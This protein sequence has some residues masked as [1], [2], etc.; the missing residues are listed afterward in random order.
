L[1]YYNTTTSS[2][3]VATALKPFPFN[4]VSDAYGYVAN[5]N[6]NALQAVVNIR[7]YHGLTTTVSYTLS[8]SIDNGGNF[9]S[10]YTIPTDYIQDATGGSFVSNQRYERTVST[11]NQPQHLTVTAVWRLP[12]GKSILASNRLERALLGGYTLSGVVQAYSGSPLA[13]TL[14]TCNT[15]PAQ[16]SWCPASYA[17]G[18]TGKARINGK[19]GKG[20]TTGT[21][22]SKAFIDST[23][24]VKTSD[25]KFGNLPRTAPYNLYGPG[26]YQADLSLSRSFPLHFIEGG[27]FDFKAQWYNITNHT[28]FAVASTALGSSTF[29]MVTTNGAANRKAAQFTARISF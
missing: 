14:S 7:N 29:G 15:N 4:S 10:G 6:Y 16:G 21:A 9:R 26:N 20:V 8:R 18:F 25:Y 24:F 2:F 12:L 1:K 17:S 11:S 5:S 27:K 28:Q 22:N 13:V 19:W 3:S 23:A